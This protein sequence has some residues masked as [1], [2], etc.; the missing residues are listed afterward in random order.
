MDSH[1]NFAL[2]EEVVPVAFDGA[3]FKKGKLGLTIPARSVIVLQ[4]D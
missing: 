3:R 4:V 1:N 2:P